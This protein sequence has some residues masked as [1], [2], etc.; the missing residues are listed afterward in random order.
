MIEHADLVL[1]G[2]S[3]HTMDARRTR[4]EAVAVRDGRI[5][6]VGTIGEVRGLA[7]PSTE[8]IDLGGRMLVPGFVDA[9]VHPISGGMERMLC[10]LTSCFSAEE[11]FAAVKRYAAEHPE[12]R[13]VL[14]GGWSMPSFPGGTPTAAE[15]DAIVPHR[16]ALLHNRD[17]HGAWVNTL[18]LQAAG[19][20]AGTPDPPDGRI[21][22][23]EHGNPT[24]TLH[25]GAVGLV[26]A[27]TPEPTEEQVYAGLLEGQRYLHSFGITGWQDAIVGREFSGIDS[28]PIYLRAVER[29]ELTARVVGA[30]WWERGRG[31]D[32]IEGFSA[33]REMSR[34]PFRASTIKI[35]QD[36]VAENFSAAML[37][38]Y[39][40]ATGNPS[41]NRGHSFFPAEELK[42]YV[43][44]ADAAGF[45][46]H[47][48]AIGDRAV[49]ECL[50]AVEAARTANGMNDLRHHIS[51][52]QV[53][54]PDDLARFPALGVAA[55]AQMLWACMEPQ[56]RDLTIPFLGEERSSWQYPFASLVRAGARLVCGSDWP[57]TSPDPLA[58][59]HTGVNR[60]AVP[61]YA[62]E[63]VD[64]EPLLPHE[65]L[66]LDTALAGYTSGSAWINHAE[67]GTGS[68]EAGKAADLAVISHDLFA[69]PPSELHT[70][71]VDLTIAGGR[72]VFDRSAAG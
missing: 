10:D 25:E 16:P 72:V 50:D 41:G 59:I 56:M 3:V 21:E 9:H 35:M 4:A 43:T 51:H 6:A 64:P 22:R 28:L 12:A 36:G 63:E 67:S 29:G 70:A 5:T 7:G 42:S 69:L 14:G 48:H 15:L 31:V 24:G 39:L 2:G 66:D 33:R 55:N 61:E 52:I 45:Q 19:I 60:T 18:A 47:F 13:W 17:H 46:V 32:Q 49:R 57:V 53:I 71:R 26:E 58:A 20:T 62:G 40:D 11:C 68:I 37:E 54:H 38:D 8:T 65:A 44:S 34:G 23:D 30:Q 27:V 1:I